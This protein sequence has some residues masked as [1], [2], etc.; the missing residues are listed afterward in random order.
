MTEQALA[1]QWP[2]WPESSQGKEQAVVRALRAGRWAVAGPMTGYASHRDLF[3]KRFA[4]YIGRKYCVPTFCGSDAILIALQAL[5]LGPGHKVLLPAL[6]WVG[7][8]TSILRLGATPVFCDCIPGGV[9]G[10]YCSIDPHSI[11]AVLAVHTYGSRLDMDEIEAH[12]RGVPVV[13]DFSHCHG[14][15]LPS[16]KRAGTGG[17]ISICSLQ[18]SKLLTC[19]EGGCALTDDR[20]LADQMSALAADS[21]SRPHPGSALAPA[22]LRHGANHALSDLNAS[23]AEAHLRELPSELERRVRAVRTFVESCE[24]LGFEVEMS[25]QAADDGAVYAL[26]FRLLNGD[27]TPAQTIERVRSRTGLSCE[28]TYAPIP[29]SA[30]YLPWTLP[31]YKHLADGAAQ[32]KYP[33]AG[34][35][36]ERWLTV[37]HW[38]FLAEPRMMGLLAESIANR[39]C[40][41]ADKLPRPER[42]KCTVVILTHNRPQTLPVALA[43]I[44]N[45]DVK[46]DLRVL[47]VNNGEP[48]DGSTR[49]PEGLR[50]DQL[51][52]RGDYLDNMA[53]LERITYLRRFALTCVNTEFVA[54]LDDDNTWTRDHLSSLLNALQENKSAAAHSW[55]VAVDHR[56]N[57]VPLATFPWAYDAGKRALRFKDAVQTGWMEK[58]SS[59]IRD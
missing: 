17:V 13:E 52:V 27:E 9:L 58:N 20:S 4:E 25:P 48:L 5:G 16:G 26:P 46:A 32:D 49:L 35:I 7:C 37:P 41:F 55:R 8:A 57:E 28:R 3:S 22:N 45:Q 42:P 24:Q 50:V 36:Y 6:T 59:L 23:V 21:R 10:D 44:A 31:L 43:S 1:F 29:S 14:A 56:G 40:Q 33:R 12:F 11:D 47:L 18:A 19:G 2:R 54:F 51:S 39:P 15:W 38:A 53:T 34:G 30:L